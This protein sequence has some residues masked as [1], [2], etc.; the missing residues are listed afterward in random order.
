MEV[1]SPETTDAGKLAKV[2]SA[3]GIIGNTPESP[4]RVFLEAIPS[5]CNPI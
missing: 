3:M 2:S 1:R 5:A 4:I